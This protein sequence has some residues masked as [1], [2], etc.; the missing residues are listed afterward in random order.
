MMENIIMLSE[1]RSVIHDEELQ[2]SIDEWNSELKNIIINVMTEW[3]GN[4]N[5]K[6]YKLGK[7]ILKPF[8]YIRQLLT[9]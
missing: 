6:A 4:R 9:R 7:I 5:S 3:E 8:N 2:K 1:L